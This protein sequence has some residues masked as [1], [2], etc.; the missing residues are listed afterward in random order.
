MAMSDPALIVL[1]AGCLLVVH[2][3]LALLG[4]ISGYDYRPDRRDNELGI[5]YLFRIAFWWFMCGLRG[6]QVL[7]LAPPRVIKWLF[8]KKDRGA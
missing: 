2:A 8:T 3:V 4:Q 6:W 1:S 7:L 5:T